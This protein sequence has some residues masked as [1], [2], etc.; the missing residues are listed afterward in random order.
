[1]DLGSKRWRLRVFS[2]FFSS[3]LHHVCFSVSWESSRA[4]KSTPP[5]PACSSRRSMVPSMVSLHAN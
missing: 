4:K 5:A 1:M 2:L 3:E